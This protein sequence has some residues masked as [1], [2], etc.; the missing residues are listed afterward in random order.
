MELSNKSSHS[1]SYSQTHSGAGRESYPFIVIFLL[2]LFSLVAERVSLFFFT[3]PWWFPSANA[4]L[5]YVPPV[6][7]TERGLF[8]PAFFRLFIF[9]PHHNISIWCTFICPYIDGPRE[10]ALWMQKGSLCNTQN[11]LVDNL[12]E[13][14]FAKDVEMTKL[15]PLSIDK[16]DARQNITSKGMWGS[17][18]TDK[19]VAE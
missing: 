11:L 2:S 4:F 1:S 3:S 13:D 10:I 18:S 17:W 12:F 9:A 7:R 16:K 5:S 19:R 15:H 14:I 6:L 8:F